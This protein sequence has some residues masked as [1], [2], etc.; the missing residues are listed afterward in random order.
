MALFKRAP[1]VR[2]GPPQ[3]TLRWVVY[4]IALS[5]LGLISTCPGV[6]VH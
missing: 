4:I 5:L 3:Y 1:A 6:I 2:T